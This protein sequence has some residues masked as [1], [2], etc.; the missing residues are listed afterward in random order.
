MFRKRFHG[1]IPS[2]F[3]PQQDLSLFVLQSLPIT[4]Q[5]CRQTCLQQVYPKPQ[6]PHP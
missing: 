1:A 3:A 6:G 2:V 5:P 4:P